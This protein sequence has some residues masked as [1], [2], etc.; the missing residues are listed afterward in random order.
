[1]ILVVVPCDIGDIKLVISL[2]DNTLI[3]ILINLLGFLI[4]IIID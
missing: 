2:T 3:S 1:M 4:M